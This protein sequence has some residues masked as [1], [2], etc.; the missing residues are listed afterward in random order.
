VE[1]Q[2]ND[3]MARAAI[4]WSREKSKRCGRTAM[5]FAIHW[6]GQNLLEAEE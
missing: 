3:E 1:P 6:L 2:W 4:K 5:P